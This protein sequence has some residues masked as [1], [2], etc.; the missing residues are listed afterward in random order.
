MSEQPDSADTTIPVDTA[1]EEVARTEP[2]KAPLPDTGGPA[3]A[4][5]PVDLAEPDTPLPRPLAWTATVIAT[6]SLFLALFNAEAI[7]GW[8][9]ELKPTATSQQVVSAAETWFEVTA[10]AGLDRPV[11]TMRGWWKDVQGAKFDGQNEQG[12]DAE[13]APE[14]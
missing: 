1:R 6:A 10:S 3:Q 5:S 13:E 14:P 11:A 4:F 12:P 8:A 2:A 7:R 9:Y